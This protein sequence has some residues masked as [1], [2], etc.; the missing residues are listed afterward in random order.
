MV[1]FPSY[2]YLTEVAELYE[3]RYGT[4][5]GQKAPFRLLRQEQGMGEEDRDIFLKEFARSEEDISSEQLPLVGFCVIGGIFS[6][7][8]DLTG[9]QLIGALVV[10]T[11]LAQ[12]STEGELLRDYFDRQGRKGYDYAYRFPGINKVFQAAGRVIRTAEDRGVVILL[13]NRMLME[14]HV[15]LFP[16]DWD[17]YQEVDRNNIRHVVENFW[18]KEN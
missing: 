12:I 16:M 5:P 15:K 4:D 6:E 13:D 11:G 7:G 3:A 10:G 9:N 8:I 18:G 2:Q 1:F 14:N 17:N